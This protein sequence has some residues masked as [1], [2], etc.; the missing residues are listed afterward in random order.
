[1]RLDP[2]RH[3]GVQTGG[4]LA[5]VPRSQLLAP[6]PSSGAEQ[7]RIAGGNLH[8]RLLFPRF[9]I[10]DVYRRSRLEVRQVSESRDINED[11]PC[12]HAILQVVDSELRA[13]F[14]GVDVRSRVTVVGLILVEDVAKRVDMAV[15]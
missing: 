4:A 3:R 12:D 15:G 14:L 8:A 10:L 13:A 11:A 7:D 1:A 2:R 9:Q 5:D 6:C